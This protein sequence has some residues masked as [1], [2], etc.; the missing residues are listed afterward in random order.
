MYGWGLDT[1]PTIRCTV[2][3]GIALQLNV[4]DMTGI[5]TLVPKVT[6]PRFNQLSYL[7]IFLNYL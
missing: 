1:L 6:C 3:K 4:I 2:G 5:C 7:H